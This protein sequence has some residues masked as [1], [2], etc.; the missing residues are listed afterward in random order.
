MIDNLI[1]WIRTRDINTHIN[2]HVFSFWSNVYFIFCLSGLPMLY[3]RAFH[4][5]FRL[6]YILVIPSLKC[7]LSYTHSLHKSNPVFHFLLTKDSLQRIASPFS[8]SFPNILISQ[9]LQWFLR[10]AFLTSCSSL[11]SLQLQ[12]S[13]S[14]TS[15][16]NFSTPYLDSYILGVS[17]W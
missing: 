7:T 4:L 10:I 16:V 8:F 6:L 11:S 9:T 3:W 1:F 2:V 12:I 14:L 17:V 5:T 13:G 15:S